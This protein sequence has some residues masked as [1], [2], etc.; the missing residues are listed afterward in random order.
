M[1]L[2]DRPIVDDVLAEAVL[3]DHRIRPHGRHQVVFGDHVAAVFNQVNQ[4]V[5]NL[6]RKRYQF[7]ATR[8]Q[9]LE[10]S[11]RKSLKA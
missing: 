11:K 4:R 9:S 8:Q 1:C 2:I 6:W 5:K 3:L 7:A 10:T